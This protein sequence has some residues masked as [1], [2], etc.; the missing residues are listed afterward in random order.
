MDWGRGQRV[1]SFGP[2]LTHG[3]VDHQ[4]SAVW[5]SGS[6][7]LYFQYFSTKAPF[8]DDGLR[9]EML[10]RLNAIRGLT[11]APDVLRR[12]PNTPLSLFESPTAWSQL[13]ATF[14]W[15]IERIRAVR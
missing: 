2:I 10:D 1:G 14:G 8:T 11:L 4:L 9:R 7:E 15:C 13:L 6:L 5:S 12:R 3:G